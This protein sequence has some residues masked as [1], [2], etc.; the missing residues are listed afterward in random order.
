MIDILR[1]L[2]IAKVLDS[3]EKET[4]ACLHRHKDPLLDLGGHDAPQRRHVFDLRPSRID[5]T[6]L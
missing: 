2:K 5:V 6:Q 3:Y 1:K 4:K